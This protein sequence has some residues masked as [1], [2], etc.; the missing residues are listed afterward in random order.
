MSTRAERGSLLGV[1][2]SEEERTA[3]LENL[4]VFGKENE[5]PFLRRM[6]VLLFLSTVI[7]SCGLLANSAEVVI[8]AML[9]APMMRP[10]MSSAGAIVMGWPDRLTGALL[11]VLGMAVAST[12]IAV[13]VALLAPD[14]VQ[15]P[16]QVLRRTEPTYFDLVIALAA[17]AGGA[18][19]MTRKETSAI[20][21]VAMAVSL[22]PP[23]ASCGIL[24]VFVEY[25]LAF[26]AFIL[27]TTNFFAMTLAAT[28]VFLMTGVTPGHKR[29]E[30]A[31]FIG[32]QIG[33]FLLMVLVIS[34]PLYYYSQ[35]VWF[36]DD[37]EAARSDILQT[38]LLENS[39]TLV[40]LNIDRENKI[41]GL[42]LTGP[43]PP[44]WLQDLH[45]DLERYQRS[46]GRDGEFT[47]QSSWI[48]SVELSWPPP[49]EGEVEA[50]ELFEEERL[51]QRLLLGKIWT[52]QRTQYAGQV[53][54][55][56]TPDTAY[57]A[58]FLERGALKVALSCGELDSV[59]SFSFGAI[60]INI[61][62]VLAASCL[63]S[64]FDSMF[65]TDLHRVVD[66]QVFEDALVL[67]LG[68]GSGAMFF[69]AN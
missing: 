42:T 60:D 20:P 61:E 44:I 39:Q 59:Y 1:E 32:T 35:K 31:R 8:G 58:Q 12:S 48:R 2:L 14:M 38:W 57:T 63:T 43:K 67:E 52:W 29:R 50:T 47:I 49:A 37:Y 13:V 25:D 62:P 54:M 4:F 27:F 46:I 55:A 24:L 56:N 41:L 9:I 33:F 40:D 66:Y 18:Y 69:T 21:G 5:A 3:V 64:D 17:G 30:S 68:N 51:T 45:T 26:R 53:W 11:M 16:E 7:A 19:T 34:V 10:V 28:V 36:D 6:G 15:I 23:L 22:M 65:L